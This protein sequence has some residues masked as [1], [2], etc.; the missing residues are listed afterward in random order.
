MPTW[1]NCEGVVYC[2]P[3]K[4]IDAIYQMMCAYPNVRETA[5]MEGLPFKKAN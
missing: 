4:S 5:R 2:L 3:V 1:L